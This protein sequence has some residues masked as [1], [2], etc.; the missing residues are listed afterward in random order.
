M[1]VPQPHFEAHSNHRYNT[2]DYANI[3]RCSGIRRT[4]APSAVQ[5]GSSSIRILLDG[6]FSH[7]GSDSVYFNRE[8]RYPEPGAFQSK[9]SPYYPWYTFQNWPEQ[10]ESWWGFTTLPNVRETN[11]E[12]NRYINGEGGIVRLWLDRG[13]SGWRLDVAT[14][15]RMNFS[16]ICVPPS[17]RRIPKPLFSVRCGRTHPQNQRMDSAAGICSADSSTA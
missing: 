16:T 10:Y 8:G 7:T 12:Y 15:F 5:P 14:S 11:P 6:V 9:D 2:A 3:D 1:C 4:S 13:A 17:R